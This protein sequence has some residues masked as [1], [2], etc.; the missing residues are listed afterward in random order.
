MNIKC[1]VCLYVNYILIKPLQRKVAQEG[2]RMGERKRREREREEKLLI[3]VM[4]EGTLSTSNDTNR[5]IRNL[6]KNSMSID[7]I[8]NIK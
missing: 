5:I 2:E 6:M 3:S 4:K 1:A 8:I 7:L